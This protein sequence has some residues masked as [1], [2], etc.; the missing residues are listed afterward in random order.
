M[1]VAKTHVPTMESYVAAPETHA[2][3]LRDPKLAGGPW[4]GYA[5]LVDEIRELLRA[6]KQVQQPMLAFAKALQDL[7]DLMRRS[8]KG[9]SERAGARRPRV[10]Q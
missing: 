1:I 4:I 2:A 9:S 6:T 5:P 7:D 8:A 3:A 10:P